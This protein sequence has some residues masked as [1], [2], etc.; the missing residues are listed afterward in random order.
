MVSVFNSNSKENRWMVEKRLPLLLHYNLISQV[1]YT[2]FIDELNS[3]L[4]EVDY[5]R[6]FCPVCG[7]QI[8]D[9]GGCAGVFLLG[10]V[11]SMSFLMFLVYNL[12]GK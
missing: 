1:D 6:S 7:A 4:I 12:C 9:F 3:A 10:M 2:L 8:K 5:R 11:G